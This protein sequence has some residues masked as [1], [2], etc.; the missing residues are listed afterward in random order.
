M[1]MR[2]AKILVIATGLLTIAVK[3][4]LAAEWLLAA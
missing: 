3:K 4:L 1:K 2:L